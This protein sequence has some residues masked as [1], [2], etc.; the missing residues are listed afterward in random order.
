MYRY[1]YAEAKQKLQLAN[2]AKAKAVMYYE[3]MQNDYNSMITAIQGITSEDE[4]TK[5]ITAV[6]KALTMFQ[7]HFDKSVDTLE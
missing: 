6:K 5:F 2:P 7:E 1:L 3:N 4:K